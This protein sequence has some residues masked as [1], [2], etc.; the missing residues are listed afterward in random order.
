[1]HR[2]QT[3]RPHIWTLC[4][5]RSHS[6][7]EAILLQSSKASVSSVRQTPSIATQRDIVVSIMTYRH[8]VVADPRPNNGQCPKATCTVSNPQASHLL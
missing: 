8:T 7:F 2:R 6:F 5:P 4:P 1:M 3:A